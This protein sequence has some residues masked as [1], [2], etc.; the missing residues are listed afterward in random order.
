[1]TAAPRDGGAIRIMTTGMTSKGGN[2][3]AVLTSVCWTEEDTIVTDIK[4]RL[5]GSASNMCI[6]F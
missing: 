2:P 6:T 4:T 5:A 3:L 1:M